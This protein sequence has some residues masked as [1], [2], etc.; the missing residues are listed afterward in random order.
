MSA[1]TSVSI[2]E[3]GLEQIKAALDKHHKLP[4]EHFTPEM[5]AA[6][7]LLAESSH[8]DGNDV[9]FEIKGVDSVSGK[10]VT[11]FITP[12]GYDLSEVE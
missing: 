7:C 10:P 1:I 11:V 9:R 6:W 4:L 8:A 2:N 5:L 12:E 3:N